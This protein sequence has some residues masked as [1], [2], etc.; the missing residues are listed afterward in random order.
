MA[1]KQPKL[2]EMSYDNPANP[3]RT[4]GDLEVAKENW[5]MHR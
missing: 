4:D 1:V 3:L 5:E 2:R